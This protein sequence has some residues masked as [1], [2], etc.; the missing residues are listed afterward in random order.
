MKHFPQTH[1]LLINSVSAIGRSQSQLG[2]LSR[3][4][5]RLINLVDSISRAT[6]ISPFITTL[7]FAFRLILVLT[8][9]IFAPSIG[10]GPSGS[11]G[12]IL[13]TQLLELFLFMPVI[14][15]AVIQHVLALRAESALLFVVSRIFLSGLLVLPFFRSFGLL[16]VLVI[17][18][19][20]VLSTSAGTTTTSC[21]LSREVGVIRVARIAFLIHRR[22]VLGGLHVMFR[23]M[24]WST[25]KRARDTIRLVQLVV[26]GGITPFICCSLR[27]YGGMVVIRSVAMFTG[28]RFGISFTFTL[29]LPSC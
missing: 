1:N 3:R 28:N 15:L 10:S 12:D 8:F 11:V 2:V 13:L 18:G 22:I 7:A 20:L 5:F 27:T 26:M 14:A 24:S 4:P 9:A 17:L 16:V 25:T 23:C 29:F 6:T 19:A 21:V